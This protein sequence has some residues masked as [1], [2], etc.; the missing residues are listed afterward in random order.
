MK[1]NIIDNKQIIGG[2]CM[3]KI[4]NKSMDLEDFDKEK[5]D[6]LIKD[7]IALEDKFRA[8]DCNITSLLPS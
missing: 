6:T 8:N 3:E 2:F 5:L 1:Y 4:I 7:I